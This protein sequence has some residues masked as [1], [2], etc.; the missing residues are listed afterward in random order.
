MPAK[1]LKGMAK[2]HGVKL[3]DL[4]RY[5]KGAEKSAKVKKL[6]GQRK[7]QYIM[8]VVKKRAGI[9]ECGHMFFASCMLDITE[10]NIE[11]VV[12]ALETTMAANVTVSPPAGTRGSDSDD[13]HEET[14]S[15]GVRLPPVIKDDPSRL[16]YPN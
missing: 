7:Y 1:S 2:K 4:E 14:D 11:D 16:G 10:K 15:T 8:G 5:W 6:K 13:D 3:K 9:T 12:A